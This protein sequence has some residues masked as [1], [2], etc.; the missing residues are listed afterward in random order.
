[1]TKTLK[2]VTSFKNTMRHVNIVFVT[3]LHLF[4]FCKRFKWNLRFETFI[5]AANIY[6][7]YEINV[8]IRKKSF[9]IIKNLPVFCIFMCF[10]LAFL[11]PFHRK[12]LYLRYNL[13]NII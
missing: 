10:P 4:H 5:S 6:I 1:M 9:Q 8:H 2:T 3:H 13:H 11:R 7:Y 12:S